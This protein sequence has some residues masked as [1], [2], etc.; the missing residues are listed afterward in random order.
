MIRRRNL[1]LVALLAA[2]LSGCGNGGEQTYQ[3]WIEGDFIFVAPDEAGRVE[4]LR[5]REGSSVS[6]GDALFSV[7]AELQEADLRVAE[8]VLAN[9][10]QAF[11]RAEQ[12]L[13]SGSGSQKAFDDAQAQLREAQARARAARTRLVRR[14][15]TS[16]VSGT[17]QQ[18]YYRP[19][20]M[21]PAG[22]AVI[23]I[24]PPG[25]IKVRFFVPQAV[26]P[27]VSIGDTV[28][29]R[30]DGCGSDV[31]AKVS[32]IASAAEYTPPVIYS[33]EERQKLVF[34]IEAR[35]EAPGGLRVGQPVTVRL[36]PGE[37]G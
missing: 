8:A 7:D 20:E 2:A 5:V 29:I 22:R 31:S 35:P 21:V 32:F 6:A 12:L 14:Q 37:P 27:K 16:P 13:K 17:V 4:N 3:G 26:L 33:L 25:N 18:V 30:C 9:T 10:K 23:S 34:L 36:Q 1:L 11:E 15:L 24:L 19:G 28:S